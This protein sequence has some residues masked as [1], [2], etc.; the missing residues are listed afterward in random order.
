MTDKP[1]HAVVRNADIADSATIYDHVNLY[2]CEIGPGSKVDAFV[3]IEEDVVIGNDCTVRPFTFI[4]TGVI[5]GD[6][7]FIGPNVTFTNDR[8]PSVSEEWTLEETVVEESVGI[9]AGATILPGVTIKKGATIGSGAV[10][11]DDVPPDTTV[12]GNPAK[13][14]E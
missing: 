2:G 3:Y 8:Y 6:R 5:V 7:V 11:T 12:V 10:V 4:P 9:G 13:P 14:V 1:K